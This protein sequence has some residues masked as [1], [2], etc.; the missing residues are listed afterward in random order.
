[1]QKN[2]LKPH[3]DLIV[4][5]TAGSTGT[6]NFEEIDF[7]RATWDAT[8]DLDLPLD[9]KRERNAYRRSLINYDRAVRGLSLQEDR[10]KQQVRASW[11]RLDQARRNYEIA[12]KSVELN[13]R[14]VEEQDM[15][16][17]LGRATA[18]NQVDAQ[19]DL[20]AAQNA[21]T[22]ALVGHTITRLEFWRD[23][24]ILFIKE[25]GQWEEVT[26]GSPEEEASDKAAQGPTG[27]V[28]AT[29]DGLRR[30]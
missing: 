24:G 12:L 23:M 13:E 14:R 17:E 2:A 3:L 26:D 4:G 19:L 8:L 6:D 15:L 28:P 25:D 18:Q 16:A 27:S 1:V 22:E 21:L 20:T 30:S 5:G 29:A 10:V 7:R 11:R 9:R